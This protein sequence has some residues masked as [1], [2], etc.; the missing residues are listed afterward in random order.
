MPDAV[1]QQTCT[2]VSLANRI[3]LQGSMNAYRVAM[4][5]ELDERPTQM[6]L[7]EYDQVSRASARA[8]P[9]E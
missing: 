1:L 6:G 4:V 8:A 9:A 7:A 3:L 2:Q 5:S